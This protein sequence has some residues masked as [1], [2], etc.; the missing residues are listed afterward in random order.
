MR[1]AMVTNVITPYRIS[2]YREL[3]TLSG[4]L[5]VFVTGQEDNR[6]WHVDDEQPFTL[7]PVWGLV[8]KR[9]VKRF[10]MSGF[11]TSYVHLPVGVVSALSRFNPDAVLTLEMGLRTLLVW[12]YCVM[13]RKPLVVHWGGTRHTEQAVGRFKRFVRRRL[14]ARVV[15]T[16]VSYGTT[17]TAYLESLGIRHERIVE[18][19]NCVD[20]EFFAGPATPALSL[21]PKPVLLSVGQWIPRKGLEAF[22]RAASI[23]RREGHRFTV[24]LVGSGPQEDRLRRVAA[25]LGL[26]DVVFHPFVQQRDLPG[27]YASADVFVFPTLEDVW[28][29]VVNEALTAGLPV[30]CSVHAGC[31]EDLVPG[32]W[33]FDPLDV[34]GSFVPALRKALSRGRDGRSDFLPVSQMSGP[35]EAAHAVMDAVNGRTPR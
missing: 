26:T 25:Q 6:E 8:L 24:L 2:L 35:R 33:R 31:V 10:G 18:A 20:H 14:F 7:T 27:I 30:L 5:A 28:G 13:R 11:D 1:L 23:L 22:L 16:W 29:L 4:T 12:G 3:A 9:S 21:A 32:R 34:E 17:S 19:T 15:P